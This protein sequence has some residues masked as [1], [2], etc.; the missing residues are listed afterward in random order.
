MTEG[1]VHSRAQTTVGC[2]VT[3]AGRSAGLHARV[4]VRVAPRRSYC[5][6]RSRRR[7]RSVRTRRP[8][9]GCG[10]SPLTGRRIWRAPAR[11]RGRNGSGG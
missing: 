1:E 10:C 3:R 4:R 8:Q 2:G 5:E 6:G 9:T 11:R 7:A